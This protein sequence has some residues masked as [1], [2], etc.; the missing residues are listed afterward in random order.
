MN[1]PMVEIK[2]KLI[3]AALPEVPFTGWTMAVL[4]DAAVGLGLDRSMDERAFPEGPVQAVLHFADLADRRLAEEAKSAGLDKMGM[5]SRIKWLVRRRI[6]AWDEHREAVRRAVSLFSLP[7]YAAK[8]SRATW[9]TADL[10]WHLAGDE[11]VDFSYYTKRLSLAAVY[12]T[13]LLS[14]LTDN[15]EGSEPSW[16]F[17]DRRAAE[18]AKVPKMINQLKERAQSLTKPVENLLSAARR[19]GSGRHFGIRRI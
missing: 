2:D 8:A 16:A 9:R 6:E 11:S 1:D 17:L 13:T 3:L 10:I 7:Q 18:L 12:S 14:W 5:T 19:Q 4:A 15:S